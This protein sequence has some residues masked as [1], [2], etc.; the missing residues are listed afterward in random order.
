MPNSDR[1]S[2]P[3]L[4][5]LVV[6]DGGKA[7]LMRNDG[8]ADRP[9]LHMVDTLQHHAEATHEIGAE[10]PGRVYASTGGG[11][12]AVEAPDYHDMEETAFL[13]QVCDQIEKAVGGHHAA[14]LVI[15]APPKVIGKLRSLLPAPLREKVVDEVGKDLAK[16]SID[17]IERYFTA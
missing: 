3:H 12:S 4:S 16:L 7:L 2:L 17:E 1:T 6:C 13:Q 15:A 5:L 11:R 9:N 8:H 10:R 14:K